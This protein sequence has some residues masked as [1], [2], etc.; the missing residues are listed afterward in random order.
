MEA[1]AEWDGANGRFRSP[2]R[3]PYPEC[4]AP[5]ARSAQAGWL[6]WCGACGRVFEHRAAGEDT[7]IPLELT[8]R[9]EAAWCATTGRE[10]LDATGVDWAGAGGGPERSGAQW[11]PGGLVFGSP[12]PRTPIRMV[13]RWSAPAF[14]EDPEDEVSSV[15][16]L[17]GHVLVVS[18]RG[19]IA[20]LSASDGR[21][22]VGLPRP[23]EWPDGSI[24]PHDPDS[25]VVT[26]PALRGRSALLSTALQLQFRDL[27]P[28]LGGPGGA[29]RARLVQPGDGRK[30]QGPPLAVDT[31]SSNQ[32]DSF[33][34]CVLEGRGDMLRWHSP[35]VLR[36]F[37]RT[38]EQVA[39]CEAPGIARP[40][41][42]DRLSGLLLWIDQTGCVFSLP[43]T[44]CAG[45]AP[46]PVASDPLQPLRDRI[47]PDREGSL[48]I[49]ARPTFV[50][51]ADER[52]QTDLWLAFS[53][54]ERELRICR[55]PLAAVIGGRWSWELRTYT[56]PGQVHGLAVGAGS[57][58]EANTSGDL[59]AVTTE[60]GVYRFSKAV[61]GIIRSEGIVGSAVRGSFDAPAINAAGVLARTSGAL[62]CD[63]GTTRWGHRIER[64]PLDNVRYDRAQ[65]L[66]LFG[67]TAFVGCGGNVVG[68][69]LVPGKES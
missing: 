9:P 46:E 16:V 57:R 13:Q 39:A 42:Y 20:A 10:L 27:G 1:F 15:S 55:A 32:R 47:G 68:I 53:P 36:F 65:G 60:M 21:A 58:Q 12:D 61:G 33:V 59:L 48:R 28:A 22:A 64:I 38:G 23:L 34:F 6:D 44:A 17:R 25:A 35:P 7:G 8:R 56:A 51:A 29:T 24:D 14:P 45:G 52:L 5:I 69:D 40:P 49:A 41:V 18:R 66:A 30:F 50:V 19:R 4:A 37:D 63:G 3:C 11:D 67:R 54:D 2:L 43:G 31:R 62:F 26:P